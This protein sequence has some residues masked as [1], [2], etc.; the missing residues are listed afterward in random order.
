MLVTE[1]GCGVGAVIAVVVI[2]F[3]AVVVEPSMLVMV[4]VEVN[5]IVFAEEPMLEVGVVVPV[6]PAI[7]LT[8]D[9][10]ATAEVTEFRVPDN[11]LR[12]AVTVFTTGKAE[13]V[14]VSEHSVNGKAPLRSPPTTVSPVPA[15]D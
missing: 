9:E 6:T 10:G 3:A 11:E 15:L 2:G 13:T 1:T 12:G 4:L 5:R 8:S 14:V 7:E